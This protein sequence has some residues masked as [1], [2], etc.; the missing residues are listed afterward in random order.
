LWVAALGD[1]RNSGSQRNAAVANG[2]LEKVKLTATAAAG[3]LLPGVCFLF[4]LFGGLLRMNL[5]SSA[6]E[7][8]LSVVT[9]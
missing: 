8:G 3:N 7:D 2:L 9:N 1:D 6:G 5:V 4:R